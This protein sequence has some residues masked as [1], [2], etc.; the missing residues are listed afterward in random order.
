MNSAPAL[1]GHR[2]DRLHR[3]PSRA[4]TAGRRPRGRCLARDPGKLRDQPWSGDVEVARGRRDVTRPRSRRAL[5]GVDVAYYLVHALGTG[6]GFEQTD[7][8]AAQRLRRRGAAAGVRRIVYLGGIASGVRSRTS[9]RTCAPAPRSAAS[10]WRCGVP[11]AALRAAVILGSGSASFEML[12]YLTER[13]PV[14]VTPQLGQHPDPADRR[15]RRAALPGR[16]RRPAAR[17]QPGFDIGGPDILS[18]AEMMGR[19][20]AVAGLPRTGDIAGPGAHARAC[21]ATGSAWSPRCPPHRPPAGRVAAL[22]GGLRGTRHRPL[23]PRPAGRPPWLRRR[24]ALALRH[25]AGGRRRHPLVVRRAPGAPSD[26][27]PTDPDWAGGCL[28]EDGRE[29]PWYARRR[30]R[31]AG[32]RGHRRRERLVLLPAR[33]GACA[34]GSTGW[35]AG[36]G[37][38]AAAGTRAG[39]GSA[40]RSTSGGSR[41]SRPG[42]LLRLRAEMRLPGLAW[43]EMT[44]G[45]AA[46]PCLLPAAGPLPPRGLAGHAYWW[47]IA[48]F[49]A[50]VFGGMARNI[51]RAAA[52]ARPHPAGRG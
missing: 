26:P 10:C 14:M 1:P 30:P 2:G 50:V 40:T 36:S 28:Y 11:T 12:R 22:R 27:L 32:R 33:V 51:A 6:A 44:V 3:W 9:P 48:P 21:R 47:S 38:A 15:P 52:R 45:R 46:R 23:R 18:Y 5:D 17:R 16:L 41:R 8:G 37:C 7:R 42:A 43:L 24:R 13:L 20:A 31:V 49:H 19:Y 35:S 25:G 29:L 39:C 4:R 34:A